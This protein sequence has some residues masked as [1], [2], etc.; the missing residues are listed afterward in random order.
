MYELN[1][2]SK[3]ENMKIIY[4]R[5]KFGWYWAPL[6]I[7]FW[8]LIFYVTVIPS[9]H[10]YPDLV[11][12][13]QENTQPGRFIGERA[14]SILFRLTKI[15]PKVVG[16]AANE[17][18]A[19]HF[20]LTEITKVIQESR[21]DLYDI[22]QDVQIASGNYVLWTMVNAYQSIQ[23][24]VVKLT[25]RGTN[26][27][28]ALLINSHYDTVPGSSGAGDAGA[29]IAI[30]LETLRVISKYETKLQHSIVFLFN[31]AEENPMQGSHA[32]ITLHKWARNVKAVINLDSAGSGGREILFQSGPDHPWLMKYYG[33]NIVHPF[34]STIGEELF[35]NGFVPS[36]TDFRIFRDFGKIP[37]LDMAHTM[38][39]FVYHTKYDRFNLIP[40]KSYQLTGDNILALTKALCN[41]PELENPSKYAEGHMVFF[42]ILGWFIVHYTETTGTTVNILICII[43][44]ITILAYIWNMAHQTG[45]FRRRVFVKFGILLGVQL[46]AVV[47]ALMLTFTIAIFMDTVG[48]SMSW[49]SQ[50][51][52]VF[53]LYFCPMF[54]M[55]GL[56][57]A[58]YLSRTKEHGLPLGY[59][60]QLIMHAHCL[61][62]TVVCIF[63]ISFNIRSAFALMICIGFYVLS[64]ILNMIT[65]FHKTTFLW[66]IPHIVCQLM[67]FLFYS[68]LCYAFYITFV[69]MQGRDGANDN[70][71]LFIGGFTALVCLVLAPFLV[72][73]LCL[74]RKSKTIISI[75][76]ATCLVFIILAATP[77][78]YPYLE[79]EAPQRFYVAHT[80]RTFHN[81]DPAMTVRYGDAG[82]YVV[83]VD[84]HPHTLDDILENLNITKSIKEEV[85]CENAVMC[86]YPIYSSRWLGWR[87][88][89]FWI[90][91]PAPKADGWPT[92]RILS[93]D[94]ISYTNLIISLEIAGPDHMSIFIA[95]VNDT[96][97]VDWSYDRTPI[98]DNFKP[99][100]F[101]YLS[102]ALDPA[103]FRFHL[104]FEHDSPDWSGATFDI[105]VIGHKV[106]DDIS[107]TDE[108]R[109]FLGEFPAWSTVSAWTSSYESWRL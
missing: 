104:E 68:Y 19:V 59:A 86:G 17:Q 99:P 27:T 77:I 39:G 64:V 95:P 96:K 58:I 52:M 102:Y 30:M 16:S 101:I 62:L 76:G 82:F 80:T 65:C 10:S 34:A 36:D 57:P 14:E 48:L 73:I 75:F 41:A 51:W 46:T 88:Q 89:S 2:K 24:V 98:K 33:A 105:A 47:L 100:Y 21:T 93:K 12:I 72:P 43:A 81:P 79:H 8:F 56:L 106:H 35:Q 31:G 70:P 67:P 40:R 49:Y 61:I 85:N 38:N 63:M 37:G 103:P 83:P 4:N 108:F 78:G 29:M 9:Y 60:I 91:G 42:D 71:E 84:R 69:P 45:M 50:T 54:F 92:L 90:D 55:M 25:P 32:F 97:L 109:D 6:F 28:A 1:M 7:A 23:N 5:S 66:L 107:N 94:R 22:Q 3:Y 13:E 74:F 44:I 18:T 53:G 26:S 87:G 15:G 11:T 20:L